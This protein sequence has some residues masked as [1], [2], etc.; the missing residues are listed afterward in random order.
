MPVPGAASTD[1]GVMIAMSKL[2]T[3]KF[4]ADKSVLS[5][6]PGLIW[7]EVY[8]FTAQHG[9][10]VNGG[11]YGQV[12]VGGLAIGG[13]IGYF[14]KRSGWGANSVVQFEVV[15]ADGTVTTASAS[16]NPD[17]W[18]ALKGGN[19]NFAIVTR[20]DMK[21]I[22]ITQA[23]AGAILWQQQAIPAFFDALYSYV[24]PGGGNEDVDAAINPALIVTPVNGTFEVSNLMFHAGSDP[25]PASLRNFTQITDNVIFRD[26][27]V[28]PWQTLPN[29]LNT[30][31]FANRDSR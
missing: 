13:G 29:L 9:L 31:E 7:G 20:Y 27:A 12:G 25:D 1:F 23:F 24:A 17:L 6:G 5:I 21:T 8:N 4:N 15:L 30:P 14:G 2:R 26:V 19:N 11:R 28:G 10:A 22:P 16:K 3:T 18:W